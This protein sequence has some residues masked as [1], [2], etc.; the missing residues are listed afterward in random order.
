MN[1]VT[2]GVEQSGAEPAI[3]EGDGRGQEKVSVQCYVQKLFS[4]QCFFLTNLCF[5]QANERGAYQPIL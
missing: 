4:F 1:P 5:K 2:L 3:L